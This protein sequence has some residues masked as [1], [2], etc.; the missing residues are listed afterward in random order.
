MKK[1]TYF[2][3]QYIFSDQ[4]LLIHRHK[5]GGQNHR[6]IGTSFIMG[7]LDLSLGF[8]FFSLQNI[9]LGS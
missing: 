4:T 7:K 3:C 5:F 1:Y 9:G 6:V 8:K 2:F